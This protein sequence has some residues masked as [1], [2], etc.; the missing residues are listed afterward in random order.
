MPRGG[1]R[2]WTRSIHRPDKSE[3]AE[4]FFPAVNHRVSKRPIWL[5]DAAQPEAALPPT[6]Q[7]IAGSWRSRSASL[8]SSYTLVALAQ[9]LQALPVKLT[10]APASQALDVVLQQIGQ[11]TNPDAHPDALMAL[12][13]ALQALAV[14]LTEAA[15]AGSATVVLLE[16]ICA[17]HPDAPLKEGGT[18]AALAWLATRYPWVLHPPACPPPQS[19][20]NSGRKC[21]SLG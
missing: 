17:R 21:P 8:T 16:E 9:V 20:A 15:A 4:R 1:R 13:Q 7:R 5:A 6:I 12:A 11:T 10:E 18:K 2:A 3:S 19:V 14:K